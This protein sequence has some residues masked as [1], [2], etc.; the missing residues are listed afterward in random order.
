MTSEIGYSPSA[1]EILKAK[2][3]FYGGDEQSGV[4]ISEIINSVQFVQ[5]IDSVAYQ[6]TVTLLDAANMLEGENPIRGE[7]T[8]KLEI[9]AQDTQEKIILDLAV[10]SVTDIKFDESLTGAQ[11]T[12]QVVSKSTFAASKR[13]II[14]AYNLKLSDTAR[15][16]FRKY[17]HPLSQPQDSEGLPFDTVRYS[18]IGSS[19]SA[20]ARKSLWIQPTEGIVDC[21]I[22]NYLPTEAMLFLGS[23][24]YNPDTP[25]NTYRFFENW[26]GYYYVTD[27][28]L[29]SAGKETDQNF[30]LFYAPDVENTGGDPEAQI[31]RVDSLTVIS[32]G[33]DTASDIFSGGYSNR[34][35]ELDLVRRTVTDHYFNYATDAEFVDMNGE[36][37]RVE[38][39]PH[40]PA[41]MEETFTRENGKDMIVFK[42]YASIGDM[43]GGGSLRGE[44]FFPQ[45]ASNRIA[46]QHH[47]GAVTLSL[48][49]KGRVDLIPGKV[50][51]LSIQKVN[52]DREASMNEQLSGKYLIVNSAHAFVHGKLDTTL[53]VKKFDWSGTGLSS[54]GSEG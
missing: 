6:G 44:A 36:K 34:V 40:S 10:Y 8:L 15:E 18:L 35:M 53:T 32:R 46:Y 1:Y 37:V 27:E 50:I 26:N 52:V 9:Q 30:N 22:P 42:D 28:F 11:Y 4:D 19:T 43:N 21:I 13:R 54:S 39:M 51:H 31:K 41:F 16:V 49:M 3:V 7:E 29:V 48:T 24:S 5:S 45:I 2:L 25:S 12:L 33:T 17:F 20:E 14:E 47:L 23:R 38:N